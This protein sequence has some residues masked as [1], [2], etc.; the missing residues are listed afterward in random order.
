MSAG[1]VG[2]HVRERLNMDVPASERPGV[3]A[4]TDEDVRRARWR[5]LRRCWRGGREAGCVWAA[6]IAT[7]GDVARLL[8]GLPIDLRGSLP[9]GCAVAR[10]VRPGVG[11]RAAWAELDRRGLML[12]GAADYAVACRPF[13]RGFLRG[14]N[15]TLEARDA[16][17]A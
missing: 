1:T 7:E 5:W 3:G 2:G 14:V 15:A 4:V 6:A 9:P 11:S 10:A 16:E 8:A 13:W 12:G 17:A